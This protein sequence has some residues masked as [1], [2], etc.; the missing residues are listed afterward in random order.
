MKETFGN[1]WELAKPYDGIV[2]TTNGYVNKRGEAVMGKG[3]AYQ[4]KQREP[5]IAPYFRA[6][7]S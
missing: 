4:A 2:I 7:T 3:I 6:T 5:E 1:I